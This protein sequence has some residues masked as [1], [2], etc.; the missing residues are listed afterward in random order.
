MNPYTRPGLNLT[1]KDIVEIINSVFGLKDSYW[2]I[3]PSQKPEDAIPRHVL[4]ACLK[5]FLDW[6]YEAS[7]VYC[8]RSKTQAYYSH[9]NV[10]QTLMNDSV[11]GKRVREVYQK[12]KTLAKATS[13]N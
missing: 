1:D 9:R 8:E 4:M 6:S 3:S 11:Y 5:D 10:K 13:I 2:V 12:C 7:G